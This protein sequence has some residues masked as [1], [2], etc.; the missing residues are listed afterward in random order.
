MSELKTVSVPPE[1]EGV[2]A[3]AEQLVS[4][5]FAQRLDAP[6][7]GTIE[8]S[9]ERYVLVRAASLSVEFFD[10]VEKLYG[11][12]RESEAQSFARNILFDLAHAIGKSDARAFHEK[13]GLVDP[14]E[15]MSAGP[16]H[17]ALSGWAS[18]DIDAASEPRDDDGYTLFYDHPYSFESDTWIRA[19]R[20]VEFPVCIM[21][22]GYSSGWCE[23][24]FGRSLVANEVLCKARGDEFCRFIM[25]PP[26]RIEERVEEYLADKPNIATRV[27][28]YE[29]PDFFARKSMEEELRATRDELEQRVTERTADLKLANDRL[30]EEMAQRERIL[31][32]LQ[33]TQRL[34]SLGRLAGGVAHDF[35][36]LLGVIMGYSS[37]MERRVADDDPMG[38][39]LAEITEAARLAAHLTRQLL[40]FSRARVADRRWID[41]N[42][43]VQ[44]TS[45]M[46]RRLVGDDVQLETRLAV[47]AVI[48]EADPTHVEQMLMN[49]A[50]NARDAMPEG[51]LLRIET[52]FLVDGDQDQ[53]EQVR[54]TVSDT[55]EGMAPEVA[56]QIFEPFFS[57]KK[58]GDATGL[59]LSTVREIIA[60]LGGSVAVESAL[61]EGSRF[62]IT[63]P[64]VRRAPAPIGS[65][66]AEVALAEVQGAT[67]LLVEDRV[68]LRGLLAEAL[69]DY[70]YVVL[71][72]EDTDDALAIS[73]QHDG[74]I[75]Y[76]VTDVVMP[77]RGGHELAAAI[78]LGRP[79]TRVLYMSGYA[80]SVPPADEDGEGGAPRAFIAKPFTPLELREAL[81]RLAQAPL[82]PSSLAPDSSSSD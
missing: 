60:R 34:E 62:T 20:D 52:A 54:L 33:N 12:G 57:T 66:D 36:N 26:E 16:V 3:Q 37:I 7:R 50:V 1:L 10:L 2:F 29:I 6:S 42:E 80:E 79:A 39:M 11:A 67:V 81:W 56:G 17:F 35:N 44:D 15:R 63:L 55:G 32:T 78:T 53:P 23:E 76:L 75:H 82:T 8:I 13:M 22:A 71:V 59:G 38:P 25:A 68:S 9:G 77:V 61:G 48:V 4:G 73:A 58:D 65:D 5:Y 69:A 18:V 70:G 64:L 28:G 24:S 43:V 31:K 45:N 46:L 30:Q 72:A 51:G 14:I 41:V 49:L 47:G 27:R 40:T 74:P 21:N 19:G